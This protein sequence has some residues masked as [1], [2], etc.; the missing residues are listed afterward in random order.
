MF[1]EAPARPRMH[2]GFQPTSNSLPEDSE[3][4]RHM[5]ISARVSP[6]VELA[7][8]LFERYHIPYF[9]E[10][11]APMLHVLATRR[12]GGGNEVPVVVS[13]EGVWKG[14]RELLQ[15]FDA[16]TRPGQRLFGESEEQRR[17]TESFLD[18]LLDQLLLTVRRYVYFHMLPNKAALHPVATEG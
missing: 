17:A 16:K 15:A 18:R 12:R 4:P 11:H 8:W 6:M 5:M 1:D 9:E 2:G 13:A 14:A 3:Q 7:R 10:A